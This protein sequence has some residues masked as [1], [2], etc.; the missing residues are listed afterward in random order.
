MHV[1]ANAGIKIGANA[2]GVKLL[3][4]LWAA[5]PGCWQLLCVTVSF[6]C[7][8]ATVPHVLPS[9]QVMESDFVLQHWRSLP[10]KGHQKKKTCLWRELPCNC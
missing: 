7:R 10:V 5:F 1:N 4:K 8:G 3:L 6:L 9:F 2:N